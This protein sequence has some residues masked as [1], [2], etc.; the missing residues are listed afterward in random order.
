MVRVGVTD[1][2]CDGVECGETSHST[3]D[4]QNL[5]NQSVK[6]QRQ[7]LLKVLAKMKYTWPLGRWTSSGIVLGSNICSICHPAAMPSS[8]NMMRLHCVVAGVCEDRLAGWMAGSVG[9]PPQ[10]RTSG[11][12]SGGERGRRIALPSIGFVTFQRGNN[13]TYSSQN[14]EASQ[15]A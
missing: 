5:V 3:I 8:V 4:D 1:R 7:A 9:D 6:A 2:V 11:T 12:K 14:V 13:G 10:T 15:E